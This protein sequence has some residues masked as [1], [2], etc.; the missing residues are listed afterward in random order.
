MND[1]YLT[2]EN[3]TE[4]EIKEK[5]SK[6]LSYAF[7][8]THE[9]EVYD[10]LQSL[11][12]KHPKARHFC[13]AYRIGTDDNNFRMNDD[14]E[15]SGTAGKP[16]FGQ[17]LSFQVTN[18][19]VVVVR[20][21]GGTKLGASGLI[22]AY[23]DAAEDAMKKAVIVE[24]YLTQAYKLRFSYELMGQVM[25]VLKKNDITLLEKSFTDSCEVNI[26]I[27]LSQIESK[28]IQI[29]A[30]ILQKSEEEVTVDTLL[31]GFDIEAI[32]L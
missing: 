7:P 31:E 20:Y 18:S 8:I 25:Q 30:G 1:Q 28:I 27:R 32:S 23:K 21:F 19:L 12:E 16:I 5:G 24:K 26:S 4:G 6:F 9:M 10:I 14:G 13:Y 15:P 2:I 3:P 29:K 11:K 17:L 22:Q